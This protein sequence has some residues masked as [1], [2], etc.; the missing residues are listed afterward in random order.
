[1]TTEK[2]GYSSDYLLP[3]SLEG[4]H[5]ESRQWLETLAFWKDE[6]KFF[7]NLLGKQQRKVTGE[8]D[9]SEM[10]GNLDRLHEMLYDYL[11]DEIL[12]HERLLS[13]IEKG[14]VAVADNV[15]REEHRQLREKMEV[16]NRDFRKFKK[17]VFSY[18]RKW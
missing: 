3:Q 7:A 2:L 11:S 6:T 16:F 15:Y 9:P 4:L 1:M 10:L 8:A 12:Q 14:A 13:D 18:A 5:H 17:M